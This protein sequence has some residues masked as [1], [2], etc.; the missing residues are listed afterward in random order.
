MITD[1]PGIL[2]IPLRIPEISFYG[3]LNRAG[4]LLLFFLKQYQLVLHQVMFEAKR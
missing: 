2:D 1:H 4:Y 3:V